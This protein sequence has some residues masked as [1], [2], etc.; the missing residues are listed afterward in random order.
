MHVP[1]CE[2]QLRLQDWVAH[3]RPNPH[4][5]FFL[6]HLC[7][8]WP[9]P[10]G[11]YTEKNNTQAVTNLPT[12]IEEKETHWLEGPKTFL[13]DSRRELKWVWWASD[14]TRLQGTSGMMSAF[15]FNGMFE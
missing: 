7:A 12:S 2:N 4:P 15:V 8:H 6:C 3:M 1:T 10:T 13:P 5:L 9:L 14:S 11:A